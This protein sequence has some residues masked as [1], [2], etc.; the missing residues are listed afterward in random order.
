[1]KLTNKLVLATALV[2]GLGLA[3]GH[4]AT[5]EAAAPVPLSFQ[6]VARQVTYDRDYHDYDYV[7]GS[8]ATTTKYYPY[9]TPGADPI[10]MD[11]PYQANYKPNAA[12]ITKYFEQFA[13]MLHARNNVAPIHLTPQM[14]AFST[15]RAD[16]QTGSKMDH[17]GH[18]NTYENLSSGIDGESDAEV[19]YNEVQSWYDDSR[20]VIPAGQQGHFGHRANM[21]FLSGE[22]GFG[23]SAKTGRTAYNLGAGTVVDARYRGVADAL[24]NP[25]ST[26]SLPKATFR[27]IATVKATPYNAALTVDY[28][29]GYGIAIWTSPVSKTVVKLSNGKTK[30]LKD[31]T[32]WK[33]F[34]KININGKTWYH[35]GGNQWLQGEYLTGN[36]PI[37][38]MEKVSYDMRIN[39][40]PG[41]SVAVFDG[42]G[43]NRKPV[44][45][46]GKV[47]TL[48]H[49]TW[50]HASGM[51]RTKNE[52]WFN[53]GGNQ[54]V[55]SK[56]LSYF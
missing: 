30:T 56:Y 42:V 54:W 2:G 16:A 6:Y 1:M 15:Q 28:V 47:K 13:N 4:A 46:N 45:V 19:A 36:E 24:S 53:F 43:P 3:S 44:K 18:G 26:K 32:K 35:L 9:F 5:T 22:A 55:E 37:P 8:E 50:W 7:L 29:P 17:T 21:T 33:V 49:G 52:L 20:N 14:N 23:Y 38:P 40:V 41:Y 11:V 34:N 27:S 48:K 39:Y 51:I 31:G 10:V 25:T 12:N